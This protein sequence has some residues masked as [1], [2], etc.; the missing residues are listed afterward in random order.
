MTRQRYALCRYAPSTSL[1]LN[2]PKPSPDDKR[3]SAHSSVSGELLL[4]RDDFQLR[5]ANSRGLQNESSALVQRMYAWR[6]YKQAEYTSVQ[7]TNESTL[8]TCRGEDV[9]GTLTIRYDSDVGLAADELYRTELDPF[10][11]AGARVAELTRLAVDPELGTKEVLGALFHAAY[12][13]CGPLSGV[14]DVFIEVNPRH[15]AFYQRLLNF[16]QSG[17]PKMC[18]RVDALAVLLHVEVAHVGEQAALYG[19]RRPQRQRSLYPYFCSAEEAQHLTTRIL[20]ADRRAGPS[21]GDRRASGR[22]ARKP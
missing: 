8:Q 11:N 6:G 5:L 9:F 13:F 1:P 17:E 20:A 10:R 12:I 2:A 15:V 22:Y 18:A 21:R 7:R 19:G 3:L 16:K 14:T 4:M